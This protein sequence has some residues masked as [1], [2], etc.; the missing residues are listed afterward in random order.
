LHFAL[1]V[2][3]FAFGINAKRKTG[4]AKYKMPDRIPVRIAPRLVTPAIF[5]STPDQEPTAIAR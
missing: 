2:L 3:H 1:P 5:L 4:N